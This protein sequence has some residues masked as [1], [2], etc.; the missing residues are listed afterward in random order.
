M[1]VL[2]LASVRVVHRL[3][4]DEEIAF[5]IARVRDHRFAVRVRVPG[6]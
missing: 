6:E 4:L 5:H 1:D 3:D 2:L